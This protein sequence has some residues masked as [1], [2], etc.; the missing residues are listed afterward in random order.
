MRAKA[1]VRDL[2]KEARGRPQQ[3]MTKYATN[4]TNGHA[5]MSGARMNANRDVELGLGGQAASTGRSGWRL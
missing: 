4:G 3:A 2:E 5:N 1:I